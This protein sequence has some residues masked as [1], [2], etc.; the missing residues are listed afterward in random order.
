MVY[1][2]DLYCRYAYV[3]YSGKLNNDIPWNYSKSN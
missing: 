2:V 1:G 3:E